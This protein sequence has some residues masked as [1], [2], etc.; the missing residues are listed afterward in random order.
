MKCRLSLALLTWAMLA[1]GCIQQLDPNASAGAAPSSSNLSNLSSWQL[2]QSP[3]CDSPDGEVPVN[4]E[5]PAIY[6]PN[7]TTTTSPCDDVEAQSIAIRQ[8]YCAGCHESPAALGGFSFVL[9]DSQ[10]ASA[11]S[12]TAVLPDGGP[13]RLLIPGNPYASRLYQ[14]V[15]AG[16]SGSTAGMPPT[17]QV[18]YPVIP[19]PSA[20]D[21]S[22]LYAWI[23]RDC[24]EDGGGYVIGG[25][26]YGPSSATGDDGGS[27]AGSNDA[28]EDA[29]PE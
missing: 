16:L 28:G 27:S 14:R 7:G 19:R 1:A 11:F 5:T 10:L 25:G 24:A 20:S 29:A 26:S 3:S 4:L 12:Q 2:C 9:D 13:Q 6:L 21:L 17:A 23:V 22:V 8:T 15:A 18:G